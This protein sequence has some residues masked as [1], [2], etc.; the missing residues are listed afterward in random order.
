MLKN[1]KQKSQ[2][3]EKKLKVSTNKDLHSNIQ[4]PIHSYWLMYVLFSL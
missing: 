4:E 2:A 3:L 1:E